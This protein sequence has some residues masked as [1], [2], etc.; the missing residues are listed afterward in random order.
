MGLAVR[1]VVLAINCT[2][3]DEAITIGMTDVSSRITGF[4]SEVTGA[5]APLTV[6]GSQMDQVQRVFIGNLVVPKKAFNDVSG[7]GFTF[8]VPSTIGVGDQE[9]LFVWPGPERGFT[10]IE[11]VPLQ[12]INSIHPVSGAP[13]DVI[14]IHGDNLLI[15]E[16]VEVGGVELLEGAMDGLHAQFG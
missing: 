12:V 1:I 11:V 3:E 8:N 2:N 9:V 5:G 6:T 7:S 10:S 4:S 14:T 15:V 16:T 13:G